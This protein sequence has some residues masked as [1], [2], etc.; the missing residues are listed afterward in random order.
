MR[1]KKQQNAI[2]RL[3]ATRRLA[4]WKA[5][6]P[7]RKSNAG[8]DPLCFRHYSV[9]DGRTADSEASERDCCIT[10]TVVIRCGWNA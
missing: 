6:R 2:R 5:Q 8:A 7:V 4:L 10:K 1:L 3:G 9:V